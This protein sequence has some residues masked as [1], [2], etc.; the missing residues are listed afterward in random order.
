[1]STKLT[2]PFGGSEL[3]AYIYHCDICGDYANFTFLKRTKFSQAH[4]HLKKQKKKR[5]KKPI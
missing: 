1:M 2:S 3:Y 5:E 4:H